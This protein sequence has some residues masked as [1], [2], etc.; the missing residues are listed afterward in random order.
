MKKVIILIIF[1]SLNIYSQKEKQFNIPYLVYP[2]TDTYANIEIITFNNN[3]TLTITDVAKK[4][5]TVF[6]YE[7]INESLV[8]NGSTNYGRIFFNNRGFKLYDKNNI[9]LFYIELKKTRVNVDEDDL[10]KIIEKSCWEV[11]FKNKSSEK[12]CIENSNKS[13]HQ[14][15]KYKNTYFLY[16]SNQW[17]YPIEQIFSEKLYFSDLDEKNSLI[18]FKI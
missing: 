15:I 2:D 5:E 3:C 13:R 12:F 9:P 1:F 8:L 18:A 6:N 11:N 16:S 4:S 10:K 17:L 7:I 14:I